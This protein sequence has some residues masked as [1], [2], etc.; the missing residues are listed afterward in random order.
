MRLSFRI[1][2]IAAVSAALGALPGCGSCA[3]SSGGD[4]V[5]H[6]DS[7]C[8]TGMHCT[9]CFC[10]PDCGPEHPC[11]D[12]LPNCG[13]DGRCFGACPDATCL[14]PTQPNCDPDS[15][16]CL[17]LC[18]EH[19]DCPPAAA[20]CDFATG[21]CFNA[22]CSTDDDCDPPDRVCEEFTCVP[23]CETHADCPA[24]QRCDLVDADHLY[25]CE[26]RDCVVDADC[27]PPTLRCDTD[28]LA[29][30]DGG[31]Y[32]VPGC[33][34]VFDCPIGY[35]CLDATGLCAVHDYGDIGEPCASG[36]DSGFCV[37]DLTTASVCTAFCCRQVDCPPGWGC[38][39]V[40]D[41]SGGEHEV[42]ACVPLAPNHGMGRPGMVCAENEDC[43]SEHCW[44]DHCVDTC[45]E[46]GDCPSGR[47]CIHL[48][49]PAVCLEDPT[50]GD[51][52]LGTLGCATTGGPG[53]C[54][55]NLCY[56]Y[57]LNDTGCVTDGDCPASR[58]HCHDYYGDGTTDCVKDL[59]V[60]LCC[61]VDDCPDVGGDRFFCGK[62]DY[63]VG[64]YS[65]CLLHPATSGGATALEGETCSSALDCRSGFCADPP[66]VCRRRCCSDGD[67]PSPATP[68]CRLETHPVYGQ[69]RLVNVCVP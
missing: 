60:D 37:P 46:H 11:A 51:D 68:H 32:C 20:T 52:P 62:V 25:H 28:G 8:A 66:G 10:Q 18:D 55:S 19:S 61:S 50:T 59:C 54:L 47:S 14:D 30:A 48:S 36:C 42:S 67:C 64:D 2:V 4:C 3:G 56:S 27:N 58:P 44:P 7:E 65:V 69:S 39:V 9:G 12:P 29:Q 40:D 34:G 35:D 57:L 41:G 24:D 23:G 31:G 16:L 21:L 6:E 22:E 33:A 38:R 5:C 1:V 43:R 17:G 15:G 49:G 13:P 26:P 53:D 45:C 63:G